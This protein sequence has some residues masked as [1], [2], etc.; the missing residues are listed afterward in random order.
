MKGAGEGNQVGSDED[1]V[2][3]RRTF[4]TRATGVSAFAIGGN[5]TR[6]IFSSS[7]PT[8]G[9]IPTPWLN[10]DGNLLKDPNGN[11]VILRGVAT[12]DPKRINTIETGRGKTVEEV[13]DLAVNKDR[14][15][16]SRVVNLPVQPGNI[17]KGTAEPGDA[18][19]VAFS[20]DELEVYLKNHVDP[21]VK[22]CNQKGVYCI[23]DYH[24]HKFRPFMDP[25]LDEEVRLFWN[26]VASRYADQSHVLFE[27]YNE[28]VIPTGEEVDYDRGKD[29]M[30]ELWS[31]WKLTAQP[32]IDVVRNHAPNN[33]ILIGSPL[34]ST[35]PQGA[36]LH[37]P[38]DGGNLL[39]TLTLYPGHQPKTVEEHDEWIAN[40]WNE[41]PLFVSEW[42]YKPRTD[43]DQIRGTSKGFGSM[44]RSW[45]SDRPIHWTAWCFDPFWT[46]SMFELD[47]GGKW[48]LLDGEYQGRFVKKWIADYKDKGIPRM[49]G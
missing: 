37:E 30:K 27:L 13:I 20:K 11:E 22:K 40:V 5:V 35:Y 10:V 33:P 47:T 14:G 18:P 43:D 17:G 48:K 42:G 32:W 24:R 44:M 31:K 38:F 15:W 28:P 6:D 39:Y 4:L 19:P 7:V 9:G 1:P 25:D 2:S 12:A 16:Y 41:V 26:T 46:P 36:V 3:S 21:A 45:F 8:A 34:W 29:Y 49:N 23:I